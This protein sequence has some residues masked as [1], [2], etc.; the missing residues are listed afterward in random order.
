MLFFVY[1]G[2][3][4]MLVCGVRLVCCGSLRVVVCSWL[5]R[6][7][8]SCSMGCRRASL[9]V[10]C[11]VSLGVCLSLLVVLCCGVLIVAKLF[12]VF[13]CWLLVAV[14]WSSCCCAACC[15]LSLLLSVVVVLCRCRVVGFSLFVVVRYCCVVV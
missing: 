10:V 14:S 8:V 1:G 6:G 15:R 11:H 9:F 13:L 5:F 12:D 2:Y 7:I 4:S 3:A